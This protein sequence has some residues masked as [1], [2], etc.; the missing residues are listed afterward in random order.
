M[1]PEEVAAYSGDETGLNER[2]SATT[3]LSTSFSPTAT[4]NAMIEMDSRQ[5][6]HKEPLLRFHQV[7]GPLHESEYAGRAGLDEAAGGAGARG[8]RLR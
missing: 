2:V 1:E 6:R 8:G 3:A 4:P 7:K 5:V